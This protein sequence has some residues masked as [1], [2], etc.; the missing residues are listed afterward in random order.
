MARAVA[1]ELEILGSHGM[2]AHAYP[3]M[4]DLVRAGVL[5]P[6]LLV[7]SVIGL[8]AVPAALAAMDT[9]PAAGVT[10]I[11]PWR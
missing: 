2:A 9:A 4:L 10:V 1:L 3:P 7:T 6:D 11:E 5:R 8:D